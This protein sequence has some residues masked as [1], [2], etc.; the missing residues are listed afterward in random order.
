MNSSP[1]T[2]EQPRIDAGPHNRKRRMSNKILVVFHHFA[3]DQK[4]LKVAFDLLRV[5][6]FIAE[7]LPNLPADRERRT[8]GNLVAA[9]ERLWEIRHLAASRRRTLA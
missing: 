4:D 3:C 1:E 6:E 8:Q 2:A 9:H 7:R 5:M